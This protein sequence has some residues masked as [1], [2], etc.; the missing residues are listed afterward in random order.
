MQQPRTHLELLLQVHDDHVAQAVAA[1]P[2]RADLVE[3]LVAQVRLEH[4]HQCTHGG[5]GAG[6]LAQVASSPRTRVVADGDV[7]LHVV[8]GHKLRQVRAS[9]L[10]VED[11]GG[12]VGLFLN[13]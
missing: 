5:E 10:G 11:V 12:W 1:E 6:L 8:A 3:P 9:E 4:Q 7:H 13:V 2:A